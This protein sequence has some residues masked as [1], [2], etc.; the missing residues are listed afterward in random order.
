MNKE[1]LAKMN[2][3]VN[4]LFEKVMLGSARSAI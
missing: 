2:L 1:K 3:T 4:F